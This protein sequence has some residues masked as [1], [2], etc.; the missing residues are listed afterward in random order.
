MSKDKGIASVVGLSVIIALIG[1]SLLHVSY[2]HSYNKISRY[3]G[4]QIQDFYD[5][6]SEVEN[7]NDAEIIPMIYYKAAEVYEHYLSNGYFCDVSKGEISFKEGKSFDGVYAWSYVNDSKQVLSPPFLENKFVYS[8]KVKLQSPFYKDVEPKSIFI[9]VFYKEAHS[10]PPSI[11]FD[12]CEVERIYTYNGNRY[13]K[14]LYYIIKEFSPECS[15]KVNDDVVGIA[16]RTYSY[17]VDRKRQKLSFLLSNFNMDLPKNIIFK[18]DYLDQLSKIPDKVSVSELILLE[19]FKLSTKDIGIIRE[20]NDVLTGADD[21]V[22]KAFISML[23]HKD[24]Y[25]NKYV[26]SAGNFIKAREKEFVEEFKKDTGIKLGGDDL[27]KVEKLL[28]KLKDANAHVNEALLSYMSDSLTQ[29]PEISLDQYN[30]EVSL[31]SLTAGW[32]S[33]ALP[34]QELKKYAKGEI[35][36]DLTPKEVEEIRKVL[37]SDAKDINDLIKKCMMLDVKDRFK[38]L[39]D[40]AEISF[41]SDYDVSKAFERFSNIFPFDVTTI[42]T[43]L[44]E[45]LEQLESKGL[46][47]EEAD[48]VIDVIAETKAKTKQELESIAESIK[49]KKIKDAL[50]KASNLQ[51]LP[52]ELIAD[53]QNKLESNVRDAVIKAIAPQDLIS[54]CGTPITSAIN[55]YST[56]R[57]IFEV[58]N[59]FDEY[60]LQLLKQL[61]PYF[62][63]YEKMLGGYEALKEEL[64]ISKE[65]CQALLSLENLAKI[66]NILNA[67]EKI[68]LYGDDYSTC[69]LKSMNKTMIN[70]LILEGSIYAPAVVSFADTK[71][72]AEEPY[73]ITLPNVYTA[74]IHLDKSNEKEIY[75]H[76]TLGKNIVEK[77]KND[78]KQYL[79]N[80]EKDFSIT[81]FSC[82]SCNYLPDP[83]K[84][85]K[86]HDV[87]ANVREIAKKYET[88]NIKI[89]VVDVDID[90]IPLDKSSYKELIGCICGSGTT[91]KICITK[92][93]HVRKLKIKL[94]IKEGKLQSGWEFVVESD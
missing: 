48:I 47:S 27:F 12:N 44:K 19:G 24:K 22:K 83:I 72:M 81:T 39:Q 53:I 42:D 7:E 90:E 4:E 26:D 94:K 33:M 41:S 55:Y 18:Y 2:L 57:A 15:F 14:E 50:I 54:T 23:D 8:N 77:I 65:A 1:F 6:I 32:Q 82:G 34:T 21:L 67:A 16:Y 92:Y 10:S 28:G 17:V 61:F 20:I 80:Q 35:T 79:D 89:E 86:K 76:Y 38:E 51:N 78:V 66:R 74:Y 25:I 13:I 88:E 43:D 91:A 84:R 5:A 75:E 60:R 40:A 56:A 45:S 58:I 36:V 63:N 52:N 31:G 59:N 68:E 3:G 70:A 87:L 62:Q 69:L 64:D 29:I 46:S 71:V 49:D 30:A 93:E 73:T 37:E 85:L 11:E 9:D